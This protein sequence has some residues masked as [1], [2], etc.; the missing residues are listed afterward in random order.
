MVGY[1]PDRPRMSASKLSNN[2]TTDRERC[3]MRSIE[4]LEKYTF[5]PNSRTVLELYF[6]RYLSTPEQFQ[7]SVTY[8]L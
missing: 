5:S 2:S 1:F 8:V 6:A 3:D 7:K 4:I